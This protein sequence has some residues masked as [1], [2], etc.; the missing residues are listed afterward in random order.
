M[1]LD[2]YC[3]KHS[4]FGAEVI[5]LKIYLPIHTSLLFLAVWTAKGR[6]SLQ[7]DFREPTA[8]QDTNS[9]QYC[10]KQNRCVA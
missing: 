7:I 8:L 5:Q 3:L 4:L 10:E 2:T 1:Y 6:K 9:H